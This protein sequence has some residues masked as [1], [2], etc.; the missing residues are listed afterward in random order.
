MTVLDCTINP[1]G[2]GERLAC[3]Y[4][5]VLYRH[6]NRSRGGRFVAPF[7]LP[8]EMFESR[9]FCINTL[10]H[11]LRPQREALISALARKLKPGGW[12][13]LTSDYYFDFFWEDPA[14]LEAGVMQADRAEIFNGWNKVTP[15][16][17]SSLCLAN[18]LRAMDTMESRMEPP[19]AADSSVYRNLPPFPHACIGGV[20]FKGELAQ[21]AVRRK[22]VM[23]LLTWNTRE[24]V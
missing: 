12:L 6:W 17:W 22:I 23:A 16:E 13:I 19:D 11:L 2:F 9:V 18:D 3:L 14:F 15:E 24:A 10:E 5:H 7:G 20:F 1:A 4:P 21:R 8:D